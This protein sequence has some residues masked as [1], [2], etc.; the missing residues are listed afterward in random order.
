MQPN[1]EIDRPAPRRTT[2]D[3]CGYQLHDVLTDAGPDLA[4]LLVGSEGTLGYRRRQSRCGRSRSPAGPAWRCSASRTLDAAV[5]AGLDLA[6]ARTGRVRPARPPAAFG[7]ARASDTLGQIPAR[8]RRGTARHL[9]GRYRAR[10]DRARLGRRSRR[11]A[12][13]A[14][15]ARAGGADVR[16]DGAAHGA[17]RFARRRSPGL[18][19]LGRGP[20]PLAFVE[21]VGVP[22]EALPEFLAGVQDIL[23]RF[24]IDR[25]VPHPRAHRAGP[26]APA[27][28]SRQPDRPRRSS[29]RWPRQST[30]LALSLGG[31]VSTQHG[32]G[33]ARTPWVERQYGPLY[34]VFRELKR[35]FDPK[36]LL[37]PGKIVGPDPS[38][39]A[40]PLRSGVRSQESGDR[41]QE[42][43]AR[44]QEAMGKQRVLRLPTSEPPTPLWSGRTPT[45][46]AEAARCTG[47]GDCRTADAPERMCPIFR[48]TGDEAATPRAK[49]NLLRVLARPGG[50]DARRR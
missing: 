8:R 38:R 46:A 6:R 20:R 15:A 29:G 17:R 7:H 4:K 44:R 50:R 27:R 25:L 18:Y 39:E 28:R 45:P 22:A 10:G 21:D 26:H 35:I 43:G 47:C 24:E 1:R 14:P 23:K 34:P 11:C 42:S 48:A 32:T 31:T 12:S 5:R 19:S 9:R 33:I 41:S 37:N 30:R 2:F 16:P 49:A 36:N 40:W 13:I 3:R